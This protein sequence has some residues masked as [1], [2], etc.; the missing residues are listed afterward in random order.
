M[1]VPGRSGRWPSAASAV[2]GVV[3]E[4]VAHSLSPLLHNTAFAALGLDWVS[5]AFPVPDGDA[6]D[7][8]RGMRAL[9][10]RGLSV[11]MPH[12]AAVAGLVDRLTPVAE[13][14]GAV[15]CVVR[16][17]D[18]LV[19]EN[20]DGEG[21]V[22]ALRVGAGFEPG[23]RRCLVA[24]AGGA[25]RAVIRALADAGASEI[26]VVNRTRA[27]AEAAAA[28]AGDRGRTGAPHDTVM[29]ELVVQAT[30]TGMA[31]TPLAAGPSV[32]DPEMLRPGQVAVDLVYHPRLTPWLEAARSRGAVALGGLGMLV[33]QAAAQIER[34]TGHTAPTEA[35]W[36]AVSGEGEPAAPTVASPTRPS[37][38]S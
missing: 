24:G 5:V 17:G 18:V 19:G 13:V 29:A 16:D 27:H 31:G 34:W 22:A 26:V 20:T 23:G 8:L 14:L 32:V 12:K 15:N 28:L 1:T 4:P 21:F 9:G 6:A 7:A 33:H 2:V 36:A 30:P 37:R 3:G 38:P 25:A 35:M 11:T 10:L